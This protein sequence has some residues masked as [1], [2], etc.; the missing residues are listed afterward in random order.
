MSKSQTPR[1]D[2]RPRG[3][4]PPS[5]KARPGHAAGKRAHKKPAHGPT[6]AA[7]AHGHTHTTI[8]GGR[9]PLLELSQKRL[10]IL[11]YAGGLVPVL[12]LL[13]QTLRG[14]GIYYA[15]QQ[16]GGRTGQAQ[17]AWAWLLSAVMPSLSL[18][19]GVIGAQVLKRQALH[20]RVDLFA[21]RLVYA[22]SVFYLLLVSA[23]LFTSPL[24]S[25]LSPLGALQRSNLFVTPV[26]GLLSGAMG[27]LFLVKPK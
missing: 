16:G 17:E 24:S 3:S 2:K 11:W 27:W 1:H 13:A 22:L 15:L 18:V 9:G 21:F 7:H 20:Q 4:R 10:A 23:V 19:T 8:A 12:I 6:H 25:D 14:D 5:D 26:Q